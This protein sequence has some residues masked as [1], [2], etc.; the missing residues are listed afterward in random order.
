ME[1]DRRIDAYIAKAAPFAQPIL[2][3]FRALVHQAEPEI[4]E[5]IKWGMPHFTLN[6]KSLVEWR[7]S[8]HMLR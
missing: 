8:R 3:H 4:V 2:A 1:T 5:T 7:P 6:G